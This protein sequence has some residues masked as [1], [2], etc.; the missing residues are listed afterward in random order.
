MAA[1]PP[2]P[3]SGIWLFVYGSM[4]AEPPFEAAEAKA[5]F[6][7]D[8]ERRFCIADPVQRG[9]GE[10]PGL[11]LGLLPGSG[12]EGVAFRLGEVDATESL[13]E[14]WRRE[15][16]YPFYRPAWAPIEIGEG[17]RAMALSFF[18]DEGSPLL[19]LEL[20]REALVDALANARGPSGP[21]RAYLEETREGLARYGVRDVDLDGLMAELARGRRHD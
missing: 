18:A 13:I 6:L 5:A 9:D 19:R 4:A 1:R 15:M 20:G 10:R 3:R 16:I 8:W 14:V 2:G 11:V 17:P 21:N 12:C 7:P